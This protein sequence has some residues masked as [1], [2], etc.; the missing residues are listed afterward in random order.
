MKVMI[1][2]E[3]IDLD[4]VKRAYTVLGN[5]LVQQVDVS[6]YTLADAPAVFELDAPL[7][8]APRHTEL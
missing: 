4:G 6:F 7:H 1:V 2:S 3:N 8:F 5:D